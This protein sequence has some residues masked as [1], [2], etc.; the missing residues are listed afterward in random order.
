MMNEW[1]LLKSNNFVDFY[2][3]SVAICRRFS[4]ALHS[5]G[6]P[7]LRCAVVFVLRKWFFRTAGRLLPIFSPRAA[8]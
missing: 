5:I 2:L 8:Y 6:V 4:F 7:E 1:I 3:C